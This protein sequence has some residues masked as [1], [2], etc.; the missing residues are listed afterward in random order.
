MFYLLTYLLLSRFVSNSAPSTQPK[1]R[2]PVVATSSARQRWERR[3][4]RAHA[5]HLRRVCCRGRVPAATATRRRRWPHRKRA[6][7]TRVSG[8]TT[9]SRTA[10]RGRRTRIQRLYSIEQILDE[11]SDIL[12]LK[13]ISVLVFILFP[14]QNFYFIYNKISFLDQW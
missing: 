6:R 5:Y 4:V 13:L 9:R 7:W 8:T 12:V 2:R 3:P 11:I 10:L 1:S 14:S